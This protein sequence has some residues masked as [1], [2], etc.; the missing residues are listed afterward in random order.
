[1]RTTISIDD[2]LLE[3][4]KRR[5]EASHIT[6][7]ALIDEALRT[8]LAR[9]EQPKRRSFRLVTAGGDGLGPGVTW[10][11]LGDAVDDDEVER[12]H[13]ARS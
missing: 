4:A 12:L 8:H 13:A 7:S 9:P 11:A 10:K 3:D 5:A 2:G 1:M 6:L